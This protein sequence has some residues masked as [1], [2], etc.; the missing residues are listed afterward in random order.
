MLLVRCVLELRRVMEP[1]VAFSDAILEGAAPWKRSLEVQTQA[2]I[3]VK[4]Q[5]APTEESAKDL[6]PAKVPT[7]EAAPTEVPTEVAAPTEVSA[8]EAD[9]TKVPAKEADPAEEPTEVAAPT[10]ISAEEPAAPSA[11]I[12][13]P[14][15]EPNIPSAQHEEKGKGEAPHSDFPGR[16]Q[17]LHHTQSVTSAGQTP[18]TPSELR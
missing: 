14:A 15:E 6:A 13:R 4:T 18:L 5:Q 12:S 8:K 9:C 3:P 2:T 16:M 10:E 11:T 7:K 17:V 1:Y